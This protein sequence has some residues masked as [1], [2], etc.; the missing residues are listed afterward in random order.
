MAWEVLLW[1]FSFFVTIGILALAVYQLICLSDLEFD[2]IN[3]YDSSSRINAVVIP[4]FVIQGA[5]CA[6]YLITWHWFM[7]LLTA[8]VTYFHIRLYM[9][10]KHLIDVT[11]IFSLLN[12]EKKIRMIKIALYLTLFI[13]ILYRLVA[14]AVSSL[15]DEDDRFCCSVIRLSLNAIY[16]GL[17]TE[18]LSSTAILLGNLLHKELTYGRLSSGESILCINGFF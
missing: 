6:I 9:Q 7:F 12:G 15:I 14:S 10:R 4:E 1:I 2:Y 18:A 13:I 8:P 16:L 11:E 5:L 3:P 17:K